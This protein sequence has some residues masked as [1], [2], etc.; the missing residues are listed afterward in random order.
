MAYKT[1]KE[2]QERKDEKR[3]HIL[4]TAIKVFARCGYHG[5][6][7]KDI[8]DEAGISVGSFYFYFRNKE[9]LFEILYDEMYVVLFQEMHEVLNFDENGV[10]KNFATAIV[11]FFSVL[12]E[13]R[14]LTKIMMIEAI[15]LNPRFEE[16]RAEVTRKFEMHL[17]TSMK[18]L[19][20]KKKIDVPDAEVTSIA[21]I[22][23]IYNTIT[24]WLQRSE[25]ASIQHFI[26]PLVIYN[27]KGIGIQFNEEEIKQYIT[28]TLFERMKTQGEGMNIE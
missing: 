19:M 16:K 18:E 6:T 15:G 14:E 8:V 9:D 25:E 22:G 21:F 3:R 27:L 23:T 26:L 11:T 13:R 28:E 7:V 12:E 24:S 5:T 20:L 2:V 17:A 10:A 1:T 4:D